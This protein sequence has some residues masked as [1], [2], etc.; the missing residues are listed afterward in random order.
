MGGLIVLSACNVEV[1][2]ERLAGSQSSVLHV[3]EGLQV[4]LGGLGWNH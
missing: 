3:F 4:W 1:E 2:P